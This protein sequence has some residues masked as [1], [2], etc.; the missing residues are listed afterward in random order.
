M[1]PIRRFVVAAVTGGELNS[2]SL[3]RNLMGVCRRHTQEVPPDTPTT[4]AAC[5]DLRHGDLFIAIGINES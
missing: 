2:A 3:L 4:L 5:N 1:P